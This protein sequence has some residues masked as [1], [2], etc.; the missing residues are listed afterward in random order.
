MKKFSIILIVSAFLVFTICIL[1]TR[2]SFRILK[3]YSP[4]LIA[5]DLN[6][7]GQIEDDEKMQI[8]GVETFTSKII[9][10]RKHYADKTS[11]DEQT[12]LSIGYLAEKYAQSLLEYKKIQYKK[13]KNGNAVIFLGGKNYNSL[14]KNSPFALKDG[15]PINQE[16]FEKQIQLAQNLEL[17]IYNN[18]SNKYHH[19]NCEYGQIAGDSVILPKKQLPKNAQSCKFCK[20]EKDKIQENKKNQKAFSEQEQ[21]KNIKPQKFSVSTEKMKLILTDLSTVFLPTRKCSTEYC[22]DLIKH[23][24]NSQKTID[25]ALYGYTDI[26]DLTIAIQNAIRRGV[27]VRMVYDVDKTD[28]NFYPDTMRMAQTLVASKADYGDKQYQ[29]YIMHN[30]FFIF[31]RK[32]VMTGSAN[33]SSTD[34]SGFNTN[35][36]VMIDSPEVAEIY[37]QEFEQ[38]CNN[39]FH[40]KKEK[41]ENKENIL[42]G[43]S[44][45]SVYF[46]PQDN[47]AKNVIIPLINQAK[48]YIYIPMFVI[49]HKK[50][51]QALEDARARNVDVKIILDAT[52][53]NNKYTLHENLRKAGVQVKTENFAGKMHAKSMVIDDL[54]TVMGSMNFSKSGNNH[55]DENVIVIENS[56][57]TKYYKNFFL[58]LWQKIPDIWLIKNVASESFDSIGS[59]FDG[60]DNDFDD[61]VDSDDPGCK[62]YQTNYSLNTK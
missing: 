58:Y 42:I 7:N 8:D 57:I 38:M 44:I 52:N 27:T 29:N 59:C 15:L 26:P 3:V 53:A 32:T 24:N 4:S 1:Y 51:A 22:L 17:R 61:K 43:D 37:E 50:I 14:M 2:N 39:K 21:L 56:K 18:K 9:D 25:M 11:I 47:I 54:Y 6:K 16:A 36:I 45:V 10:F 20:T 55:N 30:K 33:V 49:T 60:I 19:L 35:D 62:P 12:A 40:N 46:S 5:V 31:D 41:I 13:L 34:L 28:H 48:N 23:I